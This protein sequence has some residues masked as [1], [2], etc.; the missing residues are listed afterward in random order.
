MIIAPELSQFQQTTKDL[1]IM[2]DAMET[3]IKVAN[4]NEEIHK[5]SFLWNLKYPT[6]PPSSVPFWNSHI[7]AEYSDKAFLSKQC[8]PRSDCS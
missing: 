8:I 3:N 1:D 6:H 4:I 5:V 2:L 7:Y